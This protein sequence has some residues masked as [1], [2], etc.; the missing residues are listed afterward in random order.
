MSL[1]DVQCCFA[2][3]SDVDGDE[4]DDLSVSGMWKR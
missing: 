3:G 4:L 1:D 2:F